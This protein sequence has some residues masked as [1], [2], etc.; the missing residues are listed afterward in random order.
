MK[1]PQVLMAFTL[2]LGL[3]QI[4][5]A[6]YDCMGDMSAGRHGLLGADVDNDGTISRDEFTEAHK[7]RSEKMFEKLDANH[8][9]KID[10]TEREARMKM[11]KEDCPMRNNSK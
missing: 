9:G 3:A 7:A 4:A 2:T 11:M 1:I 6:G 5:H 8:D 10:K